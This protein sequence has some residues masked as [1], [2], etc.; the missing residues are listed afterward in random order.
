MIRLRND[1]AILGEAVAVRSLSS[2]FVVRLLLSVQGC[3]L[4]LILSHV[5]IKKVK[6]CIWIMSGESKKFKRL[7][8]SVHFGQLQLSYKGL[9]IKI[10]K[11]LPI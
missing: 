11:I 3:L 4:G 1:L 5:D 9:V 6:S 2:V 10:V 7:P 8:S